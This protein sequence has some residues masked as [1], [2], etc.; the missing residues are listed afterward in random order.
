MNIKEINSTKKLNEFLAEGGNINDVIK[1][2]KY[3]HEENLLI[4]LLRKNKANYT[5]IKAIIDNGININY[6]NSDNENALFHIKDDKKL[7]ISK[8]IISKGID[9]NQLNNKR[10]NALLIKEIPSYI[11]EYFIMNEMNIHQFSK[12]GRSYFEENKLL[13]EE[14]DGVEVRKKMKLGLEHFNLNL[15]PEALSMFLLTIRDS[16]NEHFNECLEKFKEKNFDF[17]KAEKEFIGFYKFNKDI[18]LLMKMKN[19]ELLTQ[20]N[21]HFREVYKE[22]E[23]RNDYTAI[24]FK[25]NFM[26][27]YIPEIISDI[28]RELLNDNFKSAND[29]IVK[30]QNRI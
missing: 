5:L 12:N 18:Q 10:Q 7:K 9:V 26:N 3:E 2:G 8:L 1:T 15:P 14:D 6:V 25:E 22:I 21:L 23:I 29:I 13:A 28:H 24:S 19:N 17:A 20:V 16:E 30:K 4:Y 11:H 27:I